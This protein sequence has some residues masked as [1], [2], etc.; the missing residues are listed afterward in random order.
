MIDFEGHSLFV[1]ILIQLI[2]CQLIRSSTCIFNHMTYLMSH[3]TYLNKNRDLATTH[4]ATN[5][6]CKL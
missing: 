5:I 1:A 2:T 3:M 6:R 4:Y